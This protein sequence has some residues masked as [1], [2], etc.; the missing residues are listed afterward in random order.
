MEVSNENGKR[1]VDAEG[2][3][4]MVEGWLLQRERQG[5]FKERVVVVTLCIDLRKVVFCVKQYVRLIFQNGK[6]VFKLE[7]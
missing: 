1:S 6:C 2:T 4:D 5:F 3:E 7:V